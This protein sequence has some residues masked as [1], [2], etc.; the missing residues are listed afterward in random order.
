MLTIF[1]I[2]IFSPRI[3]LCL[4]NCDCSYVLGAV[5]TFLNAVPSAGLFRG[6]WFTTFFLDVKM[7]L[8]KLGGLFNNYY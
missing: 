3:L 4:F 8:L 6:N 7:S 5:E 1:N 2:D